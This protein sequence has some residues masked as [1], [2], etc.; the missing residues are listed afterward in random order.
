MRLIRGAAGSGLAG[1][2]WKSENGRLVR[3]FLGVS[4]REIEAYAME[5]GLRWR[6][7]RSNADLR[8]LRNRLRHEIMP[9]LAGLNPNMAERLAATA[10]ALRADEELLETIIADAFARHVTITARGP[11]LAVSGVA[12]EQRGVRL[13]LYRRV[14]LQVKGDLAR[15]GTVHLEAI[16]RLIGP[17]PPHAALD[18]PAGVRV[19]RSYD[20]LLFTRQEAPGAADWELTVPGPG[21]YPLPSGGELIIALEAPPGWEGLNPHVAYLDPKAAAFPWQVRPFRQGDRMQPIGMAGH[22]KVKDVFI[23]AKVPR[24]L[25]DRLPLIFSG[26]RLVWLSGVRISEIA[27]ITE[28]GRPVIRAEYLAPDP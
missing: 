24:R 6:V 1:M 18:L 20:E 17:V 22:K 2:R 9:L 28:R 26:G 7:D 15:I 11:V 14:I 27:R 23:D 19:C 16:D 21:R 5:K 13:R 3:P 10:D 4:R 25:R 12:V 8:F